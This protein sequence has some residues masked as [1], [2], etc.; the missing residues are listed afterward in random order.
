MFTACIDECDEIEQKIKALP[1][2][3]RAEDEEYYAK[4]QARLHLKRG[5]AYGW[6]SQYD[7]AVH[8]IKKAMAYKGIYTE[9]EISVM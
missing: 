4:M 5:A 3:E 2:A 6:C 8:D 1:E 9:E 7:A